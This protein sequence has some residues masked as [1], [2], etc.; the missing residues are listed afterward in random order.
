MANNAANVDAHGQLMLLESLLDQAT[1]HAISMLSLRVRLGRL[2]ERLCQEVA[3]RPEDGGSGGDNPSAH[4]ADFANFDRA[5]T[6]LVELRLKI[7]TTFSIVGKLSARTLNN[8]PSS[9]MQ[10]RSRCYEFLRTCFS[11][12][13]TSSYRPKA[14]ATRRHALADALLDTTSNVS[15]SLYDAVHCQPEQHR[16]WSLIRPNLPPNVVVQLFLSM[17]AQIAQVPRKEFDEV[18]PLR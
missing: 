1:R 11:D 16:L 18:T 6:E 17:S 3:G 15:L 10:L 9:D 13:L 12:I 5:R 14:T 2:Q 4:V 7:Q 8:E